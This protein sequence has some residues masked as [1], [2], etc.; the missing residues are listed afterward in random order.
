MG[1]ASEPRPGFD[2]FSERVG[3]M[4]PGP[5][6]APLGAI[7]I[8][9]QVLAFAVTILLARNLAAPEFE[10]YAAASAVFTLLVALAPLG[11]EKLALRV[12]P[13]AFDPASGSL[14][15]A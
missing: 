14:L 13:P 4:T 2:P 3:D 1:L 11:T 12:L 10:A 7:V 5:K 8:A 15:C 9:G 6:A